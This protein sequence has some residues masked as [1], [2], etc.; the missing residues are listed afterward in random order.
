M[1]AQEWKHFA[2]LLQKARTGNE[3]A[4][5]EICEF[6]DSHMKAEIQGWLWK[7]GVGDS[8]DEAY[9]D[10]LLAVLRKIPQLEVVDCWEIWLWRVAKSIAKNYRPHYVKY[11]RPKPA[12]QH[13]TRRPKQ[14]GASINGHVYTVT[15]P[16]PYRPTE[17]KTRRQRV[18]EPL[19][20]SAITNWSMS[21]RPDYPRRLDV[22][23]ARGKLQA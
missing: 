19:N 12:A 5:R 13:S 4:I 9:Q 11:P 8:V 3:K 16:E 22:S 20:D 2:D 21:N 18:V 1:T 15:V 6:I 7:A 23:D 10:V 17:Q 14:I